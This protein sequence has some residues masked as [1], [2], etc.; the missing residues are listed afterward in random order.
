MKKLIMVLVMMTF[1][2]GTGWAELNSMAEIEATTFA[3]EFVKQALKSPT[4]AQFQNALDFRVSQLRDKKGNRIQNAWEVSGYVDSQNSY[5]AM[6]RT[7]WNVKLKNIG[8]SWQLLK[9]VQ[10]WQ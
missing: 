2:F 9:K 4:T 3:K 10:F 1:S 5:G 7:N 8:G 6:M